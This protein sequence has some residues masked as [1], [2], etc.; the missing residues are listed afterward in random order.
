[1]RTGTAT[2]RFGCRGHGVP[3]HPIRVFEPR[4]GARGGAARL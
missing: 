4:G 3:R 2:R 1:M